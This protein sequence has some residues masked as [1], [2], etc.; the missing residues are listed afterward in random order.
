MSETMET[1]YINEVNVPNVF[2]MI[3]K[4][5]GKKII[6]GKRLKAENNAFMFRKIYGKPV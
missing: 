4:Q 2:A 3:V 5:K 1:A 6:R